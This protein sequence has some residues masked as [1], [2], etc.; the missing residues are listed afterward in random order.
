MRLFKT[1][2][3]LNSKSFWGALLFSIALWCYT[4]LNAEYQ[5]I[6]E[7]PL[8]IKLPSNRALEV[9]PPQNVYLDV[10]G[11]GWH[12]FN[13]IFFN[14]SKSCLVDLSRETIL[15]S[16]FRISKTDLQKSI[17]F[18]KNVNPINIMPESIT[19]ATGQIV[20]NELYVV[21]RVSVIPR[22]GFSIV[23]RALVEPEKIKIQ[24]NQRIIEQ[25]NR[26]E[27]ES[28]I[29][30]NVNA[31]FSS[32]A[33]LVDT[34][35]GVISIAP[36]RVRVSFDVQQVGDI[37][38]PDVPITINGGS[39]PE[40]HRIEPSIITLT[41]SGGVEEIARLSSLDITA[42]IEFDRIISDSTGIIKPIIQLP[43]NIILLKS[44][45]PFVYH[46]IIENIFGAR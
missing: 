1:K 17:Q 23:G 37:I 26:W 16:A 13:L 9:P 41:L 22:N 3:W 25:F 11:T 24:G 5:T 10:R 2:N 33:P 29:F 43:P 31:P 36:N 4:S 40:G 18:L 21:P 28:V 44:N 46:R 7:V 32:F 12:L 6:V 19:L 39:L 30:S 45:P 34:L 14:K 15:D 35:Q 20:E 38:I 42:S 8:T 27:T